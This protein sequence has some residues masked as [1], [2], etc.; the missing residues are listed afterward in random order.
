MK[1]LQ[2]WID[3]IVG[4]AHIEDERRARAREIFCNHR[5]ADESLTLPACWRR[6][7]RIVL[8]YTR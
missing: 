7:P 8:H 5:L 3:Q 6:S 2:H 1:R 4:I